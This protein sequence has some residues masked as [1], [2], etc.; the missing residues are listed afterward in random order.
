MDA[1]ETRVYPS[2]LNT[3]NGNCNYT[4]PTTANSTYNIYCF[5]NFFTQSSTPGFYIPPTL[6]GTATVRYRWT[7]TLVSTTS[8]FNFVVNPKS[9]FIKNTFCGVWFI[10]GNQAQ[11]TRIPIFYSCP[12]NNNVFNQPY[13]YNSFIDPESYQYWTPQ[14]GDG[15]DPTNKGYWST[16]QVSNDD[17]NY[18]VY[19]NYGIVVYRDTNFEG[20]IYLNFKNTTSSPVWVQPNPIN[21][22][23]SWKL[24]YM[25]TE[26]L[27]NV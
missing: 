25:D 18:E 24:F 20:P 1:G 3:Y 16:L 26:I 14:L 4:F 7:P 22:G 21:Q 9:S 27:Q 12:N 2:G 5:F 11:S 10:N 13:Q 15:S 8:N 17:N 6:V 23:S 19:P